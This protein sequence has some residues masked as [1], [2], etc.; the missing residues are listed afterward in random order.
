ME[1]LAQGLPLSIGEGRELIGIY[2]G[3]QLKN[4]LEQMGLKV[5]PKV[6]QVAGQKGVKALD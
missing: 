1:P 3:G 4:R 5:F 6:I 2:L